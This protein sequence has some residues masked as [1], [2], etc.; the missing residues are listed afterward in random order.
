VPYP[1]EMS[2]FITGELPFISTQ[3]FETPDSIFIF[4]MT[5]SMALLI[6][7]DLEHWLDTMQVQ[8]PWAFAHLNFC[9]AINNQEVY[10]R[11]LGHNKFIER[12]LGVADSLPQ[13]P[14][15][16][17]QAS[18]KLF[19]DFLLFIRGYYIDDLGLEVPPQYMS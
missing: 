7:N 14:A 16:R 1:D 19:V 13:D 18:Q 12:F 5:P 4:P 9:I 15:E 17:K 10:Y 2:V 6:H 11:N 3:H 8:R